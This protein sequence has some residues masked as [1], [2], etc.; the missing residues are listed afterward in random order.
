VIEHWIGAEGEQDRRRVGKAGR[1]DDDAA[2]PPDLSG[3]TPLD[4]TAQ[5]PRQ[6][7]AHGA[8]QATARQLEH[9][10]LDKVD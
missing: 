8:A 5:G 9:I 3:I 7:L 4:E 2:K 10:A 6:I 1:L